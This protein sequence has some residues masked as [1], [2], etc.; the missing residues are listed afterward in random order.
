MADTKSVVKP[1]PISILLYG[2]AGSGKSI[3]A[4]TFPKALIFDA[5]RSHKMYQAA[6]PNNIVIVDDII[7]SLQAAIKKVEDGTND[8]FDTIVI[9]SLTALENEAI[10]FAKGFGVNTWGQN[11]YTNKGKSLGYQDWGNISGSTI[12]LLTYMRQLPINLVIITQIETLM[13]NG[14]MKY[15]PNL[16][17]KGQNESLHF[18]DIVGYMEA[19]KGKTGMERYLHMTSAE[20]DKFVAKARTI[21]GNLPAIK[22]P[23][24]TKIYNAITQ[25]EN[26]LDFTD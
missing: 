13:D 14:V 15:R 25:N 2:A 1:Q 12:A 10:A 19:V 16:I 18:S 23:T 21:A 7:P 4:N 22:N 20:D 24:Y 6:F 8:K 3:L 5:D 9:D 11:L 26:K 17:G